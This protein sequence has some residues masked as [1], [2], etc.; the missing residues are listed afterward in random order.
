MSMIGFQRSRA[1]WKAKQA[2][3]PKKGSQN[4]AKVAVKPEPPTKVKNGAQRGSKE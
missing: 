3:A 1:Q 2:A 4:T